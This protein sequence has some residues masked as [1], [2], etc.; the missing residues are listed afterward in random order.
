MKKLVTFPNLDTVLDVTISTMEDGSIKSGMFSMYG[1]GGHEGSNWYYFSSKYYN[2]ESLKAIAFEN[3][4]DKSSRGSVCGFFFPNI[5]NYVGFYDKNGNSDFVG[6]LKFDFLDKQRQSK[7]E[8]DPTRLSIY[9]G[10]K[11]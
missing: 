1:T 4:W 11:S 6:A 5:L 7:I 8:K 3:V 2:P 9:I 10:T